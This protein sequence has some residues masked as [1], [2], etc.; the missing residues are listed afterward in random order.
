VTDLKHHDLPPELQFGFAVVLR[1]SFGGIHFRFQE[2]QSS[3]ISPDFLVLLLFLGH[4][5][6][7]EVI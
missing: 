4:N 3:S 5:R 2:R 7:T 6:Q 1:V